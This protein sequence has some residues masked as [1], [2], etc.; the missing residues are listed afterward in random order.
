MGS[1]SPKGCRYI[2]W[3]G[4]NPIYAVVENVRSLFNVGA[5]FRAADGVN[6]AAVYLTGF[7][8]HPPR[9]EISRV[10]LGAEASVPWCCERSTVD[11]IEMLRGEG[12][13]ILAFEKNDRSVDYRSVSLSFPVAI[14][15]GHEVEGVRPETIDHCD[16]VLHLPMLGSKDSLNV[17]VAAGIAFY[18][19]LTLK[20]S[21]DA[22]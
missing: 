22:Q 10:A 13:Q 9:P 1:D 6:A 11:T 19:V 8:G 16:A 4:R 21:G 2:P 18:H 3:A 5:V 14:V 17:S 7:T 12:V 20:E 15:V